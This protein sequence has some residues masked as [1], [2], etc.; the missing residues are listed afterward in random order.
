MKNIIIILASLLV[1]LQ[2]YAQTR[3]LEAHEHGAAMVMMAMEGEKL[4]LEFEVPSESIVGFEHFPESDK[5]RMVFASAM[6]LLSTPS[7][8]FGIPDEAECIPVG[9]NV[10]QT[11]FSGESK[12]HEGE[13]DEH[14]D[15]H[16]ESISDKD[17]DHEKVGDHD[18]HKDEIHSEFHA[19][20]LW[21][22]HHADDL[23]A[24]QTRLMKVF[25]RIEEVRVQWIVGDLQG[26]MEL[27]NQDGF[28]RGWN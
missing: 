2:S 5:D 13:H 26:A 12:H 22:C 17:D 19:S 16:D 23:K 11:L 15:E 14:G 3:Q 10:S 21:N 1:S 8:L 24:V 28:I 18:E 9:I 27:E 7:N 20:Y 25:P 4:H 6:A